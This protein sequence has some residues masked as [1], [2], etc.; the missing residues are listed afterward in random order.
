MGLSVPH[1]SNMHLGDLLRGLLEID[2]SNRPTATAALM[3]SYF[4]VS[5]VE[6]LVTNGELVDRDRKLLAGRSE[7][8]E[9]WGEVWVCVC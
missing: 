8:G 3:S 9:V 4:R 7:R 5:L 6:G 1:H 2:P